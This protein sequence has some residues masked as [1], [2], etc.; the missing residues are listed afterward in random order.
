MPRSRG[1]CA[2]VNNYTDQDLEQWEAIEAK[3]KVYGKELGE[4]QTPHLQI[5][6]YFNTVKS[7]QQL[8]RMLPRAHFEIQMG[9]AVDAAGYCKKGDVHDKPE[10]GWRKFLN[11]QHESWRGAEQGTKPKTPKDGGEDEK[12][13]YKRAYESAK[14][15][16]LEEIPADILIR[17]YNVLKKIKSEHQ[18][19]PQSLAEMDFWWYWGATGTG[20]SRTAREENPGYYVKDINKWWDG[21]DGQECT[22]IEEW[23]PDVVPP[24]KQKLKNWLDHHPFSAETKGGTICIRPKKIIVTSNYTMEEC[25]AGDHGLLGPLQRRVQVREF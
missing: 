8:K 24:L 4:N 7:L 1:W 2:T 13:R 17:H 15:G 3:Y 25:F 19:V 10:E 16:D 23:H 5:Y 20:K 18:E 14:S 22:I 6:L 12:E 21:F 9:E 11:E